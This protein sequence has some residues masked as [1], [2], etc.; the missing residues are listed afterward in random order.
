MRRLMAL[1]VREPLVHVAVREVGDTESDQDAF[2]RTSRPVLA[3]QLEEAL[4]C[5]AVDRLVRILRGITAGRVDEDGIVREEP[6]AVAGAA[7][8]THGELALLVGQRELE[9]RIG[10]RGSLS[11]TGRADDDV[12]RQLIE[13]AAVAPAAEPHPASRGHHESALPAFVPPLST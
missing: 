1:G 4:P 6:S 9:A 12:P 2:D 13:I 7:D 11:R 5:G 8:T 10:E 3:Q